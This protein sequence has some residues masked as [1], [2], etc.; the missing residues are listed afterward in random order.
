MWKFEK[1]YVFEKKN[2]FFVIFA[3]FVY[4][5]LFLRI[6]F[7]GLKVYIESNYI[8]YEDATFFNEWSNSFLA[9]L[10]E[11]HKKVVFRKTRLKIQLENLCLNNLPINLRL[12]AHK[13]VPS[14]PRRVRFPR[15]YSLRDFRASLVEKKLRRFC[16]S[17]RFSSAL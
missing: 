17:T 6:I 9:I 1:W 15:S 2:R 5:K 11:V 3:T 8:I 4:E 7:K 16:H 12:R 13:L 14:L 10:Y